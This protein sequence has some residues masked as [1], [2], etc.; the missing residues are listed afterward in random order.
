MKQEERTRITYEKILAGAI[1]EFGTKSYENASLNTICN[2]NHIAKGL[3]YHN[4]K[5]KD[6]LYLQCVKICFHELVEYLRSVPF[7]EENT[8][9][10]FKNLFQ[11]RQIFF[12]KILIMRISFSMSYCSLLLIYKMNCSRFAVSLMNSA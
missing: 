10:S 4:F 7:S 9:D 1:K 5:N 11:H 8:I 6:D 3:L 2:E 12:E